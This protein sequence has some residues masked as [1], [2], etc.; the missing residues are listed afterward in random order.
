MFFTYH[1][2]SE[3]TGKLLAQV[4]QLA[5]SQEPADFLRQQDY[6]PEN[7]SLIRWGSRR[8]PDVDNYYDKVINAAEAIDLCSNKIESLRVM[9][10]N[11]I[12]VPDFCENPH[13]LIE[14][15]GYPILGRKKRHARGT[16]VKLILQERD[17]RNCNRDYFVEYIPTNREFRVHVVGDK[18]IR[19]QGKYLDDPSKAKPWIRNY[20]T[21]YRFRAPRLRLHQDRLDMCVRAVKSLGLHF[22]AVD[23]LIADDGSC[24]VLEVNTAPSC[25]PLTL[26]CYASALH[27]LAGLDTE[28][29]LSYLSLLDPALEE[30]DSE[31]EG[32]EDE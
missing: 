9:C 2:R 5:H 31:D 4:L 22:G 12:N 19:V 30:M 32:E 29:D 1:R 10:E 26:G 24:Y 21:G 8:D 16:D 23:L 17:L 13:D 27:D 20:E 3:P 28:I 6:Q 7:S 18:V 15:V 25:S 14:E 11:E